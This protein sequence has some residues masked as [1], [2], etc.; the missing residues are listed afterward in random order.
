MEMEFSE[1]VEKQLNDLE[2]DVEVL[3]PEYMFI[4]VSSVRLIT[5][6]DHEEMVVGITGSIAIELSIRNLLSRKMVLDR[7]Q[8]GARRDFALMLQVF[9]GIFN[10]DKSRDLYKC[11]EWMRRVRNDYA[12]K[13]VFQLSEQ[14][15]MDLVNSL[16][17]DMRQLW[18][19]GKDNYEVSNAPVLRF[20]VDN[21]LLRIGQLTHETDMARTKILANRRYSTQ[22]TEHAAG[23]REDPPCILECY[24]YEWCRMEEA[25]SAQNGGRNSDH[26]DDGAALLRRA[27][28]ME[29]KGRVDDLDE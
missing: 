29:Q 7:F 10:I 22:L 13:F 2:R 3:W 17:E 5:H 20:V 27:R 6:N 19:A 1:E 16:R 14:R 24:R 23:K 8:M 18:D 21:L 25:V 4:P 9:Y 11:L 12:H 28:E 26:G 15:Q